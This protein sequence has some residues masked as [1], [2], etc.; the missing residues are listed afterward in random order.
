MF[1]MLSKSFFACLLIC[2]CLVDALG[3]SR[4]RVFREVDRNNVNDFIIYADNPTGTPH[5]VVVI[6]DDLVGYTPSIRKPP[7]MNVDIGRSKMFR[8]K[9]DELTSERSIRYHYFVYPGEANPKIKKVE[10]AI[11]LKASKEVLVRRLN[12]NGPLGQE[13]TVDEFFG[14][15]F[16]GVPGDTIYA[17]RAGRVTKKSDSGTTFIEVRHS[18]GTIGR[19]RNFLDN[20]TMVNVGDEI[21]AGSELA[22]FSNSGVQFS[23][24]Y[25]FYEYQ[26]GVKNNKWY[27]FKYLIPKF[28]TENG[29]QELQSEFTYTAVLT[30]ELITQEMSRKEKKNYLKSKK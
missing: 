22:V 5:H 11:P 1:K 20:S 16:K 12:A 28:K 13:S 29:S 17:A 24:R 7:S 14:L 26:Q 19:Y 8:L 4:I 6:F 23:V 21:L 18:D 2:S 25:L 30:D 27:A 3:Q 15:S 10:Y 9:R